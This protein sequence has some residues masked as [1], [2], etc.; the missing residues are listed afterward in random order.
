[1]HSTP[2]LIQAQVDSF[3][4]V[5]GTIH[6]KRKSERNL[7]LQIYIQILITVFVMQRVVNLPDNIDYVKS[8]LSAFL[9]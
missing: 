2:I 6:H 1:M 9:M 5:C 3:H 8:Q 4:D 7:H